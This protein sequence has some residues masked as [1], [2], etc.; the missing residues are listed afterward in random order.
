MATDAGAAKRAI[1]V[2]DGHDLCKHGWIPAHGAGRLASAG[3]ISVEAALHDP[4][5]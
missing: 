5:A 4:D 3:L 2:R 1:L